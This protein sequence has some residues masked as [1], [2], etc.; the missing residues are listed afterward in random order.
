MNLNIKH[1]TVELLQGNIRKNLHDWRLD[2]EFL[3]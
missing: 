2:K 3:K 1:K